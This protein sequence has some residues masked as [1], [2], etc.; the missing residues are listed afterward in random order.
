MIL[1]GLKTGLGLG[2]V[3]LGFLFC[4]GFGLWGLVVFSL[5]GSLLFVCLV[6]FVS[7]FFFHRKAGR[8]LSSISR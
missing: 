5:F 3:W 2:L 8:C 7:G 6:G 1:K 4:L